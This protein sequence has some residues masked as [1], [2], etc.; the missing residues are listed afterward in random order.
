MVENNPN[1]T[2]PDVEALIEALEKEIL[3][4]RESLGS[5]L[6]FP[7]SDRLTLYLRSLSALRQQAARIA[8]L[9]VELDSEKNLVA[10]PY[11]VDVDEEHQWW[12]VPRLTQ[13][14]GPFDTEQEAIEKCEEINGATPTEASVRT[15]E[16]AKCVAE[17]RAKVSRL[18]SETSAT[19]ARPSDWACGEIAGI[20]VAAERLEAAGRENE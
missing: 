8:E 10:M 19:G 11:M 12:A 14:F 3:H 20:T 9:E 1:N 2:P 18:E 15:A 17:L 6:G 5:A 7:P 13:C 4:E 16:R